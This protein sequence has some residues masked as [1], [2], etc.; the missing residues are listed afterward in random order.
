DDPPPADVLAH[1]RWLAARLDLRFLAA[2]AA[3][4]PA[5][6]LD[7]ESALLVAL[8]ASSLPRRALA[9]PDLRLFPRDWRN[10]LADRLLAAQ[11]S[12]PPGTFRWAAADGDSVRASVLAVLALRI[13][14]AE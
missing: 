4:D 8:L 3:P 10:H 14:A 1:V 5:H 12:D 2:G 11:V 6:P 13:A 9:D 7:P